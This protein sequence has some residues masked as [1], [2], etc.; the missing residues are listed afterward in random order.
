M[1]DT[2]YD[3]Q[4]AMDMMKGGWSPEKALYYKSE[5]FYDIGRK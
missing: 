5:L 3:A 2:K 4:F 1:N